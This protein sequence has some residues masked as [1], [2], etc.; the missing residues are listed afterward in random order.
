MFL[1]E[2][3]KQNRLY[4]FKTS[5]PEEQKSDSGLPK[6]RFLRDKRTSRWTETPWADRRF[7]PN[8]TLTSTSSS[9]KISQRNTE[10]TQPPKRCLCTRL[11]PF[12]W[13]GN[14]C[15]VCVILLKSPR[16]RQHLRSAFGT[17]AVSAGLDATCGSVSDSRAQ[18]LGS[19]PQ[20]KF[21]FLS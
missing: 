1:Y 2:Q 13:T 15:P 10:T 8:T 5:A 11:G 12:G 3:I 18:T 9:W 19:R 21:S 20:K 7:P 4:L 14:A 17:A 6:W 16:N